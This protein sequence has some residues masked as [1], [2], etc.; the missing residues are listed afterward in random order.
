MTKSPP[1]SKRQILEFIK[2]SPTPVGKRE[3]ARAFSIRG[4]G[5]IALKAILKEL[6]AEGHLERGRK[7]QVRPAGDLPPVLVVEVAGTDSDGEVLCRPA[8]W[9]DERPAPAIYLNPGKTRVAAPGTGD[10]ILVRVNKTGQDL[11]EADTIR[12]LGKGPTVTVGVFEKHGSYGTIRPTT[13]GKRR[14]VR[15]PLEHSADARDGDVVAIE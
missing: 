7:R 13:R 6:E 15:V 12:L 1:I 8:N 3:I 14:D 4:G 2:D 9:E 5:R 10:R 11:Y